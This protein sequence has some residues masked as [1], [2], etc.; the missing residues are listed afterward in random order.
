MMDVGDFAAEFLAE[1]RC[2]LEWGVRLGVFW[3]RE[4][5]EVHQCMTTAR[6]RESHGLCYVV[7]HL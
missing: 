6:V 1:E 2:D 4:A 7:S 5:M 3:G